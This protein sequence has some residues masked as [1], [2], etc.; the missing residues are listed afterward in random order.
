MPAYI[1]IVSSAA[2]PP[3]EL[4][5]LPGTALATLL[6]DVPG[7]RKSNIALVIPILNLEKD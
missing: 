5:Y 7:D 1:C 4:E 3:V 2:G 6:A